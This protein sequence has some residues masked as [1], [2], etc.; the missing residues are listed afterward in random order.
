MVQS[1]TIS[2]THWTQNSRSNGDFATLKFPNLRELNISGPPPPDIVPMLQSLLSQPS[3]QK[4]TFFCAHL[5]ALLPTLLVGRSRGIATLIL[6]PASSPYNRDRLSSIETID[7][8]LS[9]PVV[10]DHLVLR[11]F[12]SCDID[13]LSCS[14]ALGKLRTLS[15]SL[16][17]DS[18]SIRNILELSSKSLSSLHILD[19][20]PGCRASEDLWF[21][22]MPRLVELVVHRIDCHTAPVLSEFLFALS[23]ASGVRKV[24]L[25][26]GRTSMQQDRSGYW[27]MVD[28]HLA[29]SFSLSSVLLEIPV[30]CAGL[31]GSWSASEISARL[32]LLEKKGILSVG[33]I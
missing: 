6:R 32:P 9:R 30:G 24:V 21:P 4:I 5:P 14:I 29:H 8:Q 26:C 11:D 3:L 20:W 15:C 27:K 12:P 31:D 25:K 10:V 1:L 23:H 7:D 17:N 2:L 33:M 18:A 19:I 28:D 13:R 16:T 22:R